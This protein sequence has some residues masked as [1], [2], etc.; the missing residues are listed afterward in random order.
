V[1]YLLLFGVFTVEDQLS[2][3]QLV[4]Y[5]EFKNQVANKNVAEV[6]ARGNSIEGQLRASGAAGGHVPAVH[7]RA[8]AL[9]E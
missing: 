3:P 5:T 8:A 1:S 7:D 4:P 9:R 6:F 2:E